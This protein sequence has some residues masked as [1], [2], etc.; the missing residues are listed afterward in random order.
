MEENMETTLMGY[1]GTTAR[2]HSIIPS[3][4]KASLRAQGFLC[5]ASQG[6]PTSLGHPEICRHAIYSI[7]RFPK[8]WVAF[9][10]SP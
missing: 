1:I 3:Y 9:W 6:L 5:L 7:W 2:I 4:P 10:G 8:Q